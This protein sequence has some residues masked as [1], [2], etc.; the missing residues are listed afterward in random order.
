MLTDPAARPGAPGM[1]PAA[2]RRIFRLAVGTALCLLFSQVFAWPL[3]FIA[4]VLV[5][6]ILG[7]PLPAPGLKKSVVFIL[8]LMMPFVVGGA[9]IL[10]LMENAR[11]AGILLLALLLFYTFLYTAKGGAQIIGTFLTI[12]LTLVVT[13]GS[14][15]S[16]VFMLLVQSLALCAIVGLI[17]VAIA[18]ALFPELP[19]DPALAG[20]KRPGPPARTPGEALRDA[21]RSLLV[22][23][24]LVLIFLF[25]SGSPAYTVVMIKVATLG[26]QANARDSWEMGRSLLESTFW[27]G[28]GAI[29][30]WNI[31]A[32]W[33]SLLMFT[34]LVLL[35]GLLFGRFIFRGPLVHPKFQMASYAYLTMLVILAPAVLDSPIGSDAG[36]AFWSRLLLF[37]LISVYGTLAVRV[38]DAF[39]PDRIVTNVSAG[40][41][42]SA[43]N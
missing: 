9:F 1:H 3:S 10:P 27:G 22:V 23:L 35:A 32:I 37:V 18:H 40:G 6:V 7:L 24:P 43:Q 29:L 36:G 33:P 34:L 5:L 17:F 21:W 2:A 19:P 20:M 12:S 31:L 28:L 26:Q 13:I 15:S 11:W 4:P 38:F 16:Q 30:A 42:A 25:A 8:A 14:V 39:F 41:G